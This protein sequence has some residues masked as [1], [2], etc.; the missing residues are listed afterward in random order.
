[1]TDVA[2]NK[3]HEA[4][5]A[6]SAK[7]DEADEA[8]EADELNKLDE[9]NEAGIADAKANEADAK[10]NEADKAHVSDMPGK[11]DVVADTVNVFEAVKAEAVDVADDTEDEAKATD[12]D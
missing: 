8:D 2:A 4:D 1:M 12:A 7:V 6:D 10:A 9:A 5:E 11:A 3:A